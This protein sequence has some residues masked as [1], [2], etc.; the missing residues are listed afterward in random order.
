MKKYV[1]LFQEGNKDMREI[2]GGK[3][4]NLAEM[5]NIG[6]PVPQ[7]FTISTI[8]CNDYY[9][10]GGR[11][12][13]EIED[14]IFETLSKLE[15]QIGKK[16]GDTNSPLLLS[17]RSGAR[18][19]MPGMMDTILNLG[20]NDAVAETLVKSTEN[21]RFVYDS[22]RRFITMY[23][24]VVKGYDRLR[25]ED[26]LD[27][28]K[29][30]KN[31]TM[32]TDLTAEDM[33][34]LTSLY[35]KLY[36]EMDGNEFPQDPDIQL[37]EA[38][39][40]VFRSWN[41]ERAKV[42]RRMND[43]P[44]S[45]GTAVNV[46]QMVYGNFGEN[47]G[48]GVAFTRNPSTGENVLY[49]EYLINAQGED[50]VAGIRTPESIET[51]K[52]KMPSIYEEFKK[53][54][55]LLEEHYHDMQD[56]EFTIENGKLYMLQTRNGKR[57]TKAAIKI[58]LD[59]VKEGL[60]T[61]EEAILRVS[62]NDLDQMLHPMFDEDEL[63]KGNVFVKG[64]A[65]SP[66]AASGKIYFSSQEV[67][68]ATEKGEDT[69]LVRNETSPEDI[70]GM[71]AAQ[72][73]LT[74][75]GG[76]TS[77]A[78]V[79][80][81]GMGKCCVSGCSTLVVDLKNKS[82]SV[83]N[84]ILHEGDYISLDGTTGMVYL[85][86][87][88]TVEAGISGDFEEFMNMVDRHRKLG[89]KVN[90]DTERDA[91]QALRFGAEGIGLCR[92]EHMF[93]EK[94][95]IFY[96]RQMIVAQ[97]KEQRI[98]ALEKLLDFQ[99]TDFIKLFRVMKGKP[100]TIRYL[101]PPLHEFLPHTE[102]EITELAQAI[103]VTPNLLKQHIDSLK[104]VNPMMGHRGCRLDVT[105]PEI[106]V[107]Q[108]KAIID[109][110]IVV[111]RENIPVKPEIMIPLVMDIKE[112]KYVKKLVMD[113]ANK[114][115]QHHG[116]NIEYHV[117]TMIEVPRACMLADEIAIEAEFFSFGTNDLTQLTYGFSRDDSSKFMKDYLNNKILESDPFKKLDEDGVGLMMEFAV[118]SGR[119]IRPTLE[120]GICGEHGGDPDSIAFCH[121]IGLNYVSCSPYRVPAAR[122]AAAQANIKDSKRN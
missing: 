112:L 83:G 68:E 7:G 109:A 29:K 115:M 47:S 111:S 33:K 98:K 46:Q 5:T 117:G 57:T 114:L 77:H 80:A 36:L 9:A 39:Q 43:I 11:V 82:L 12:S 40:A 56:M 2:L 76:M 70:I 1:Y 101:D 55:K 17:V 85:G 118:N 78:A 35:K 30:S 16:L 25:F 41:T 38:V 69:I 65:A 108:T 75:H 53:N 6:L 49:G 13:P 99:R 44:D 86:Q 24:D 88:K 4:A 51:L 64:L 105:Y 97:T 8:A 122:L 14:E 34:E 93:F 20:M 32:D 119:K 67:K 110:A 66:G 121:K 120:L 60:I 94:N 71:E 84:N 31:V 87:I 62:P 19:S 73:I 23:A 22:Y 89:V 96:M 26:I 27:N 116:I 95:R 59:Q 74:V 102:G 81:R 42:Y 72:G 21:P 37:M 45:W 104:E 63:K 54:A 91:L 18:A 50:V 106:A 90:A 61:E 103:G 10:K 113:T 58:A 79:V 92:T 3:G 100:I 48:T 52:E 28:M 15:Q 107:M